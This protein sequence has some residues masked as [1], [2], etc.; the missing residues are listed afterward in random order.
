MSIT[1]VSTFVLGLVL[2]IG[3]GATYRSNQ[4]NQPLVQKAQQA[5]IADMRNANAS[6]PKWDNTNYKGLVHKPAR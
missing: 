6:L 4:A 2:I 1:G 3:I 5:A